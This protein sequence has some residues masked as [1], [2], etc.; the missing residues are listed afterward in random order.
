METAVASMVSP[1]LVY[2]YVAILD[3]SDRRVGYMEQ[4]IPLHAHA[5]PSGLLFT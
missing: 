4:I 3:G 2:L 1:M 5:S